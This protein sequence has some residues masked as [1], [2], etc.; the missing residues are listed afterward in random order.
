[1]S[2]RKLISDQLVYTLFLVLFSVLFICPAL[3]APFRN[4]DFELANVPA[5]LPFSEGGLGG[6]VSV[7]DAFPYW[8]VMFGSYAP[9]EVFHNN[10]AL[11]STSISIIGPAWDVV[12]EQYMAILQP[13]HMD[14]GGGDYEPVSVSL[15]QAG[16]IPSGT[17]SIRFQTWSGT[18]AAAF[19]ILI[20]AH[21]IGTWV[22]G[23]SGNVE[24][25]AGDVSQYAGQ[26]HSLQ[27]LAPIYINYD[28]NG[29]D[30]VGGGA[31]DSIQFSPEPAP[32]PA[33]LVLLGV[34]GISV[35]YRRRL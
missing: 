32:E 1:M 10:I 11:G 7:T 6:L 28:G 33:S 13:G 8:T 24:A 27:I 22:T 16:Y 26:T 30:F 17:Q 15:I 12:V 34:C 19:Q 35:V 31:I 14:V 2:T 25:I 18:P 3:A 9:T 20:D 29:T 5:T 4:L 23:T 21:S